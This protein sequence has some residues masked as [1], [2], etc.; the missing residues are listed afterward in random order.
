MH[1]AQELQRLETHLPRYSGQFAPGNQSP[2]ARWIYTM[3]LDNEIFSVNDGVHF[4]LADMTNNDWTKALDTNI[5]GDR[6][7]VPGVVSTE[8]IN[9]MVKC[10]YS[11]GGSAIPELK[12][13]TAH[14]V[15]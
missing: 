14:H 7:V 8:N 9:H 4:K 1:F 12:H 11:S 6:F 10:N 15:S 5:A 3:D 2:G 13:P